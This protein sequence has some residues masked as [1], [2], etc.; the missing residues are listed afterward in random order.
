MIDICY[1]FLW[2]YSK[3]INCNLVIIE[4]TRPTNV[5]VNAV[6]I[7]AAISRITSLACPI[8]DKSKSAKAPPSI[9]IKPVTV[10]INPKVIIDSAKN[11][12]TSIVRKFKGRL[13]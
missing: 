2:S 9:I 8:L 10:P 5:V 13:L 4:H 6:L 1:A 3:F 12:D 7:P 11:H